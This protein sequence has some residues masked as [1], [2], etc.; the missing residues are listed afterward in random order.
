M[1]G[2][3]ISATVVA[4]TLALVFPAS[5][6]E[7]SRRAQSALLNQQAANT[8]ALH[9]LPGSKH[10]IFL[11][12][13]G[14]TVL[15]G[16]WSDEMSGIS[17]KAYVGFNK[18]GSAS[19]FT[20]AELDFIQQVWRRVAEIYSPFDVDV[21]TQ[22]PGT[23]AISRTS[24]SD[25]TYGVQVAITSDAAAPAAACSARFSTCSGIASF[26]TF[27]DVETSQSEYQPA[28]VFTANTHPDLGELNS[29]A[30]TAVAAAHEAGH[31]FGLDHDGGATNPSYYSGHNHWYPVMGLANNR[32]IAQWSKGQYAGATTTEDDLAIISAGGAPLRADDYP[33]A[34]AAP[35][36]LGAPA[37]SGTH[38][39]VRRGVITTDADNDYFAFN[40]GCAGPLLI[41]AAGIGNG[42]TL[43]LKLTVL[44]GAGTVIA[45]NNPGSGQV[46]SAAEVF[47]RPTG[48]DASVSFAKAANTT[49]RVKVEGVGSGNPLN[50]G[51]SGYGS[52]GQYTLTVSRCSSGATKPGAP[53]IGTAS[54]GVAGTPVN[55]VA[56]WSAPRSNGGAALTKYRLQAVKLNASGA[57]VKTYLFTSISPSSTKFTA[58]LPAG[59]YK[60][61]VAATNRIGTGAYSAYSKIVTA[62]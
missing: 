7:V 52:L 60:F 18:A 22:D 29:S 43:D 56:R 24:L 1:R 48:L 10:T 51:Y 41:K 4:L 49:F 16:S 40:R 46:R 5:A 42:A 61:R 39:F 50:T 37:A 2:R 27:D 19:T 53:I 34:P 31:T 59:R 12:F 9:S 35:L 8:F 36:N 38:A 15:E 33:T 47:Y 17:A 25:D 23:D 45:T 55:A 3:L 57:I 58:A 20:T 28:W 13:D 44:N 30:L 62:R 11:D 54:S 14:N 6:S 21:T 26:G 32:A